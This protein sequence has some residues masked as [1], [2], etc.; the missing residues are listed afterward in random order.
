MSISS[1]A[2]TVSLPRD[3]KNILIFRKQGGIGDILMMTP[4][5]RAVW[6]KFPDCRITVGIDP[7]YYENALSDI[8]KHNPYIYR[9]VPW[10]IGGTKYAVTADC[11]HS[12]VADEM[13]G[14]VRSRIDMFAQT[15]GVAVSD[16]TPIYIVDEKEDEAI[17]RWMRAN[18]IPRDAKIVVVTTKS[19]NDK[20]DW[21][22][23][24]FKDVCKRLIEW[25]K[26]IHVVVVHIDKKYEW[27]KDIRIHNMCGLSIR[28]V[29]ALIR[30]CAL[31]LT[32]DT[33]LLH[34][35]A[36]LRRK[37]VSIFGSTHPGAI[38]KHYPH[39][40]Y[41]W[42]PEVCRI[43]PCWYASKPP[44]PGNVYKKCLLSVSVDDVL[45]TCKKLIRDNEIP[46]VDMKQDYTPIAPKSTASNSTQNEK[47]TI[48]IPTMDNHEYLSSC[49]KS[50]FSETLYKNF[51]VV[52]V[53]NGTKPL[54][55]FNNPVTVV[56]VD[57]NLG[58]GK[59]C[60]LGASKTDSTYILFLNDDTRVTP[61]WLTKMVATIELDENYA[62]VGCKLMYGDRTIQHAGCKY[63]PRMKF[64]EHIGRGSKS[65]NPDVCKVV[66]MDVVTG[67]CMLVRRDMFSKHGGF[68]SIW[69][70]AYFEDSDLCLKFIKAG[71]KN[72]YCG[73][74]EV[75]HHESRTSRRMDPRMESFKKNHPKF[76]HRWHEFI[77]NRNVVGKQLSLYC[78]VPQSIPKT[79]VIKRGPRFSIILT[80]FNR[81]S[82]LADAI[83][84]V[85]TQTFADWELIIA[86]DNSAQDTM[87]IIN[88]F[89]TGAH[90]SKMKLV[91]SD[92]TDSARKDKVR[93]S[94]MINKALK[95]ASGEII[96]Y[97]TD[98]AIYFSRKLEILNRVY[99][100][101][102]VKA[103]YNGQRRCFI[104]PDGH[105][106]RRPGKDYREQYGVLAFPSSMCDHN[107]FS[108]TAEIAKG[109]EWETDPRFWTCAD[110]I[111]QTLLA[112]RTMVLPIPDILDEHK[113]HDMNV[114]W[115]HRGKKEFSRA[116][117]QQLRQGPPVCRMKPVNDV[118]AEL[119]LK[120]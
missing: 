79:P 7:S 10:Q 106:F 62:A 11:T 50:I 8:L 72:V 113:Y 81:T 26:S 16:P 100:R 13:A 64:F 33:G 27:K 76:I 85:I 116:T 71:H 12:G 87:T 110:G 97:L 91:R 57:G 68:D 31:V 14:K 60:N 74:A 114:A 102:G 21:P 51:D 56:E 70:P 95:E 9:V 44:C 17:L 28:S 69:S 45:T 63:N 41:L 98:D 5:I 1:L 99:G 52:V 22:E 4:A 53:N 105:E 34:L 39:T 66:E 108:H 86:D 46:L 30:R 54:P 35:A 47:V 55:A 88:K 18:D 75:F 15:C 96:C 119:W 77:I 65:D 36:A 90:A 78:S 67:A 103:V 107:S 118:E 32:P 59:A 89:V 40:K 120:Q 84:S 92:V 3:N 101:D 20:K 19:N 94:V 109:L 38:C 83:Q 115:S 37:C 112:A 93:Y 29:G 42:K 24:K 104:A 48:V 6:H 49:I 43:A 80:S 111:F 25:D 117:S 58:F 73:E 82:Y 2:T 23:D 61:G